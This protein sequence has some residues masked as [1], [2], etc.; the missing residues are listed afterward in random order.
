METVSAIS[1]GSL[2]SAWQTVGRERK[3]CNCRSLRKKNQSTAKMKAAQKKAL[4][5][6]LEALKKSKAKD[7]LRRPDKKKKAKASQ[8]KEE[9]NESRILW[10]IQ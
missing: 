10:T 5:E 7:G 8:V 1:K 6:D 4:K 3:H 9:K 2:E